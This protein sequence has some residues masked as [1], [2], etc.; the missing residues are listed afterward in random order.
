MVFRELALFGSAVTEHFSEQSD[1]DFIG[2]ILASITGWPARFSPDV[3]GI[4]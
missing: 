1:L 4:V 2:G 3:A